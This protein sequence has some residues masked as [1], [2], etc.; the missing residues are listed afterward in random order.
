MPPFNRCWHEA[1]SRSRAEDQRAQ[2]QAGT[3]KKKHDGMKLSGWTCKNSPKRF[4]GETNKNSPIS[5]SFL[6]KHIFLLS[7]AVKAKTFGEWPPLCQCCVSF[8]VPPPKTGS[9]QEDLPW[10]PGNTP[11]TLREKLK[12]T[13]G[14]PWCARKMIC[15]LELKT[16]RLK[17]FDPQD[18]WK[19]DFIQFCLFFFHSL[20]NYS[21]IYSWHRVKV[22]V[23]GFFP[24]LLD[25]LES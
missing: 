5:G 2:L 10:F 18:A 21:T 4:I 17:R 13:P 22:W 19:K 20:R 11:K 6:G 23:F 24:N 9:H 1:R 16:W 3:Q 7:F 15:V 25:V 12:G 8:Q 14:V